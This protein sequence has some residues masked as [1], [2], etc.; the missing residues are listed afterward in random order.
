MLWIKLVDSEKVHV[1]DRR[2]R[3]VC[4]LTFINGNSRRVHISNV[5]PL[6]LP[7]CTKCRKS[8]GCFEPQK[9]NWTQTDLPV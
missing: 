3:T 6:G 7:L 9:E 4:G 2:G 8:R 5:R 1:G